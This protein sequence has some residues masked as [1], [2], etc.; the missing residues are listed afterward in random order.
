LSICL[1]ACYN[2][3]SDRRLFL[4][5]P[6]QEINPTPL[7]TPKP[8]RGVALVVDL[9]ETLLLALLLYIAVDAL[10][11]RI[12]VEG[13][14]MQPSLSNGELVL[15]N[16]LAYKFQEPRRGDIIIFHFPGDPDREFIK[17]IIGLPGD[18][19]KIF[20]GHVYI[21]NQL[22]YEPYIAAA[23]AYQS[24]WETPPDHL[25]VLGD[26]RNNSSDSHSWGT[27]P[28]ANVVGKALVIY[29]PVAAWGLAP[30]IEPAYAMP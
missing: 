7:E 27:V 28:L 1:A 4:D 23:P 9:L 26:N 15:V 20:N 17:R 3:W 6:D 10:S 24:E 14:S 30:N 22:I 19:I 13:A 18:K 11:A 5:N 25:F 8:R 12:R 21:N 16:K 2:F 29:W